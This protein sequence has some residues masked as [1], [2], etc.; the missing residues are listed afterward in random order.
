[1]RLRIVLVTLLLPVLLQA[2]ELTLTECVDYA[3]THNTSIQNKERDIAAIDADIRAAWGGFLPK[4]TA[5]AGYVVYEKEP[6]SST[7]SVTTPGGTMSFSMPGMTAPDYTASISASQPIFVG[8]ALYYG[9]KSQ[10]ERK[11][12]I[13]EEY[14]K[15]KMDVMF[16]VSQA[17]YNVIYTHLMLE[18]TEESLEMVKKQVVMTEARYKSGEVTQ[19][20]LLQARVELSNLYPQQIKLKSLDHVALLRL[21]NIIGMPDSEEITV[22]RD[23]EIEAFEL[24]ATI[25]PLVDTAM[26]KRPDLHMLRANEQ[27]LLYAHKISKGQYFPKVFLN[28]SYSVSKENWEEDWTDNYSVSLVLSWNIFDGFSRESSIKKTGLTL[29]SLRATLR[30]VEQKIRIDVKMKYQTILETRERYKAEEESVHLSKQT[31]TLAESSYKEGLISLLD[32]MRARIGY[33]SSRT[34]YIQAKYDSNLAI[35]ELKKVTGQLYGEE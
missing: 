4:V 7:M 35:L 21:K 5:N 3:L 9:L 10:Y 17:Y 6:V 14:R 2:K 11:K 27:S 20:D 29:D 19:V 33:N 30:D 22:A 28:G 1:M 12:A 23:F 34:G 32:L 31:L 15:L 13:E 8:G 26:K 25:E 16:E 24:P 18:V